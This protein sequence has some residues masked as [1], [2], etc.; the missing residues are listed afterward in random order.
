MKWIS[1][2]SEQIWFDFHHFILDLYSDE[3]IVLKSGVP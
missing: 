3:M 2:I 1:F